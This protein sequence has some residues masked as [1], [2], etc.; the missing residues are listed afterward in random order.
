MLNKTENL[1]GIDSAGSESIIPKFNIRA[2]YDDLNTSQKKILLTQFQEVLGG[3]RQTFY[4]KMSSE[5]LTSDEVIFFAGIF[6]CSIQDLYNKQQPPQ[7]SIYELFRKSKG[8][9][10]GR[11]V[12]LRI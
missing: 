11:Q 6:D 2:R 1:D 9:K 5:N 4:N 10:T 8:Y 3:N 12:G 7:P